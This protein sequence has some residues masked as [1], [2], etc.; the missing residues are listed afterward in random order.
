MA[1]TRRELAW[2]EA[3]R[4]ATL[5]LAALLHDVGRWLDPDD[6]EPHGIVGAR[7]L[8]AAG[9]PD[10]A[11]LVAHHS[12]GRFEARL[13]GHDGIDSWPRPDPE[14][15]AVLAYLDRTTSPS[16]DEV[17]F[18]ERRQDLVNRYGPSS[19]NVVVFDLALPEAYRGRLLI[20]R[21]FAPATLTLHHTA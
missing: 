10:A 15:H 6:A 8:E 5:T 21:G 2:L 20:G 11:A 7:L 19:V 17:S 14:L 9:R 3:D 18:A 1:L 4:A 13:R 12:G 16:G